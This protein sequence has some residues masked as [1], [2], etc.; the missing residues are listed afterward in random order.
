MSLPPAEKRIRLNLERSSSRLPHDV[1][2]K[3]EE[4]YIREGDP[5]EKLTRKITKVWETAAGKFDEF[6][7]ELA[8]KIALEEQEEADEKEEEAQGGA[9]SAA[10]A[11]KKRKLKARKETDI[12]ASENRL[13]PRPGSTEAVDIRKEIYGRLWHAQ[14]EIRIA[15]D[16]LNIII[17]S[18][19]NPT[20]SAGTAGGGAT[21]T[22]GGAAAGGAG[23]PG[24]AMSSN[25]VNTQQILPPGTLRCEF[26]SNTTVEAATQIQKEKMA[27]G[28]KKLQL[29][30]ARDILVQGAQKLQSVV[31]SEDNFWNSAL[32]LRKN[33]WCIVSA[34]PGAGG[35][36]MHGHH[37]LAHGSQLYVHYGFR[38]V[39]STFPEQAYAEIIRVPSSGKD[40]T[41]NSIDVLI[42]NQTGKVVSFSLVPQG[43]PHTTRHS[44]NS[45]KQIMQAGKNK[46]IHAQLHDAQT[47]IFDAE[48]FQEFI[49][50]ARSMTYSVNIVDNEI[51]MPI[52]DDLELKISYRSDSTN[53]STSTNSTSNESSDTPSSNT[54]TI[55]KDSVAAMTT[56]TEATTPFPISH[57][58][59][60]PTK[61]GSNFPTVHLDRTAEILKCCM[62]LAQHKRHRQ[63][64]QEKRDSFF[65]R[66]RPG[67]AI[68]GSG[69]G[70]S[71]GGGSSGSG[72]AGGGAGG[73]AGAPGAGGVPGTTGATATTA[74]GTVTSTGGTGA[75]V[76]GGGAGAN[77]TTVAG[78]AA[79][80]G[81]AGS[82]GSGGVVSLG[83]GGSGTGGVNSGGSNINNPYMLNATLHLLQY[84]SFSRRIREAVDRV[85]RPFSIA[86]WEP[87]EVHTWD[88]KQPPVTSGAS[89]SSL[90]LDVAA[91]SSSS[92]RPRNPLSSVVS[93]SSA[94]ASSSGL[95][96]GNKDR[97]GRT[98]YRGMVSAVMGTAVSIRLGA[99]SA[100]LRF[101]MR[102]HPTPCV[103]V[104]LADRPS[105][106]IKHAAEFEQ[107]LRQELALRA[108]DRL[109][110]VLNSIKNWSSPEKGGSVQAPKWIVDIERQCVGVFKTAT[111]AA[112]K[113]TT[114][115]LVILHLDN[116]S[117]EL[118][119]R[120]KFLVQKGGAAAGS[121][122]KW[123]RYVSLEDGV[124]HR[125]LRT[126]E[127][128]KTWLVAFIAQELGF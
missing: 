89:G 64:I 46:S 122:N 14:G 68:G 59:N 118:G 61:A 18:Y 127:A 47:S 33:N 124:S 21:A 4:I 114:T 22:A 34:K 55:P 35:P 84:Y 79:G 44:I 107:I 25:A 20:A 82:G 95:T 17:S 12:D 65:M 105:V 86:W 32:R 66:S 27:I 92:A 41:L 98:G 45:G 40:K 57:L 117:R 51:F 58:S 72:G 90:S 2:D 67:A 87:V 102:S 48:L 104:Q 10:A 109:C 16:V 23:G 106:P 31:S 93:A 110:N 36:L 19:Q 108:V 9:S 53:A 38:D 83:G 103:V 80:V 76:G 121:P 11:A 77:A 30:V 126:E 42:P 128:F 116:E 39:G 6:T 101:V 73:S 1:T 81:G 54:T 115:N 29:K 56:K 49:N 37:R 111:T 112:S 91:S 71:A 15:L 125:P 69:T 28:G 99:E 43:T 50:E 52:N 96:S 97:G 24:G 123:T 3:A 94:S 78:G 70:A 5:A 75:G 13:V 88:M 63:N 8:K 113:N 74:D 119:L 62:R 100:A 120:I 7:E 85:M 60:E 26:T